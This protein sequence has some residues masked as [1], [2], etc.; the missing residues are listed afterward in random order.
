MVSGKF[1][2]FA[3]PDGTGFPSG[4]AVSFAARCSWVFALS[5]VVC[6][7]PYLVVYSTNADWPGGVF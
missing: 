6:V 3:H 2:A 1:A 7:D 4:V 5:G